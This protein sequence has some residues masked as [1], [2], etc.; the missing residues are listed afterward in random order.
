MGGMTRTDWL[1]LGVLL[2]IIVTSRML[3]WVGIALMG[4]IPCEHCDGTGTEP[5]TNGVEC[6]TCLGHGRVRCE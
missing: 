6:G 3:I 2:F 4:W 1:T 5:G